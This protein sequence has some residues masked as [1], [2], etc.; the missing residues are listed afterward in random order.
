[1]KKPTTSVGSN[2]AEAAQKKIQANLAKFKKANGG[3]ELDFSKAAKES[4]ATQQEHHDRADKA[5]SGSDDAWAKGK[6]DDGAKKYAAKVMAEHHRGKLNE[7]HAKMVHGGD[8]S[9]E[10]KA[11]YEKHME[12]LDTYRAAEG[13]DAKPADTEKSPAA[14]MQQAPRIKSEGITRFD[15]PAKTRS[16]SVEHH[17]TQ[18]KRHAALAKSHNLGAKGQ[19]AHAEAAKAHKDAA[20]KYETGSSRDAAEAASTAR[21]ATDAAPAHPGGASGEKAVEKA[22]QSAETGPR[23]GKYY[24]SAAGQKVYIK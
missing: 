3:K 5:T 20:K 23:G 17:A 11:E 15:A 24:I 2:P 22:D 14:A 12:M 16:E 19:A 6:T 18:A 8:K 9:P 13:A 1:M 10:T 21:S 4:A 7:L